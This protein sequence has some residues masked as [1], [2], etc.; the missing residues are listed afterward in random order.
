MYSLI[1]ANDHSGEPQ[2]RK[3]WPQYLQKREE[4]KSNIF[5]PNYSVG[6]VLCTVECP[7]SGVA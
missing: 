4:R 5:S 3:K 7:G 6:T 1:G 2:D